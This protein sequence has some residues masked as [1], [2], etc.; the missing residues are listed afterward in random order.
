MLATTQQMSLTQPFCRQAT[1]PIFP[2]GPGTWQPVFLWVTFTSQEDQTEGALVAYLQFLGAAETVTGSKHLINTSSD[3]S[4]R[5]GLQVLIDCG[6]FQG[7]KEWRLRN[8]EPT[9]VPAAQIDAV[10]LT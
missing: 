1:G 2:A 10:I 3:A 9:P 5:S 8:W 4:G 7:P 6:L